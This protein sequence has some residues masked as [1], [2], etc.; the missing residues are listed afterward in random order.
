MRSPIPSKVVP[1]YPEAH[2]DQPD[3]CEKQVARPM[4]L[5]LVL[6]LRSEGVSASGSASASVFREES[7]SPSWTGMPV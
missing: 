4:L 2:C 1:G 7:R 5:V 6:L 3:P